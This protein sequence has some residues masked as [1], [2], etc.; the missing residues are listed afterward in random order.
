MKSGTPE[1]WRYLYGS[2]GSPEFRVVTP[3]EQQA[4]FMEFVHGK[5]HRDTPLPKPKL[6]DFPVALKTPN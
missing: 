4:A 6:E 2:F 3:A 5:A 1:F